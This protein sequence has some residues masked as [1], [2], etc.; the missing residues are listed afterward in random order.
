MGSPVRR[1]ALVLVAVLALTS[2]SLPS[3]PDDQRAG[4]RACPEVAKEIAGRDNSRFEFACATV[5]VPQ[6]W[7][8]PD[9]DT[10]DVALLRARAKDQRHRIGSLVVNPGGPGASG[11]ELAVYLGFGLPEAV[12]TRFDI[13]GFDPRGV[14]RSTEVACI[15]DEAKDALTAADPDPRSEAEFG[16]QV[17]LW[18]R[19]ADRCGRAY[20]DRLGLFSTEQT[21]RD[22]EAVRKAVG[23]EKTT[24]LGYSYGTLLGA[25]YAGLF[26]TRVRAAVLDGAVD[27]KA[28][29]VEASARQAGG[30]ERAFDDF[31]AD[32]K[33]RGDGCAIG[34]DARAF[35]TRLLDRARRHPIPSSDGRPVTAGHVLLAVVASLYTQS[36]W[37]TLTRALADAEAGKGDRVLALAD[38]YNQRRPDGTYTNLI[39]AN[40]TVN[41]ADEADRPTVAEV[42]RLQGEWRARYPVFGPPL[43]LSMLACAVWPGK[44]DPYP[45]GAASG[46]PPIVVI[47]TTGDPAT[48][49]EN[50]PALAHLLGVGVVLTWEGEGH[51][52]Y[53][54]TRCVTEAV[55]AYL[56]DL[57]TPRGGTRCPAR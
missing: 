20:G 6:D 26:P 42:R 51:T 7:A 39:D 16:G 38:E 54:R 27:P 29:T 17:A 5:R 30:F 19:V 25:V 12:S 36:Q 2:C 14:G 1:L 57:R 18:R 56:T 46:A 35:L 3:S 32:C 21:A 49:Y 10:F 15:P 40:T 55:D 23:D 33:G 52:A 8:R 9:G 28:D 44:P 43:A 50:T 48:P 31:A 11:V 53:P 13:V 37:T 34:P 45:T 41:C 47:G 4:W 22:L 24:Y